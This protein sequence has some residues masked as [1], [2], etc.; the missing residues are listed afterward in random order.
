MFVGTNGSC[1]EV[2]GIGTTP[3]NIIWDGNPFTVSCATCNTSNPC[4]TP[5]PTLTRTVTPT[6]T[7]TPTKTP[8]PTLTRT[9]PLP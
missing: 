7:R 8:T 2:Q 9:K 3:I 4:P 6:L 5:T 1:F